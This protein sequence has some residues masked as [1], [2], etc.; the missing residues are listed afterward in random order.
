MPI[1]SK[2]DTGATTLEQILTSK[3]E[4]LVP[5]FQRNYSWTDEKVDRL[6]SDIMEN[7]VTYLESTDAQEAQYLMGPMVFVKKGNLFQVI[8]GQQRLATVTILFCVVRDLMI[9]LVPVQ[10]GV[11][12]PEGLAKVKELIETRRMGEHQFWTL[13]LNDSDKKLFK[14]IQEYEDNSWKTPADRIKDWKKDLR[15]PV[16]KNNYTESMRKIIKAYQI[17]YDK[18]QESLITNFESEKNAEL[19]IKKLETAAE[20]ES[21]DEIKNNPEEYGIDPDFFE[22]LN[23]INNLITEAEND[24]L[25]DDVKQK[26][27]ADLE[28][29][30]R[31]RTANPFA[32]VN[33]L[34]EDYKKNL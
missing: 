7:F 9:E 6:W 30:N 13:T 17:L 24:N 25:V 22:K 10:P 5:K 11:T 8:D 2:Y 31:T 12:A 3:T 34:L 16:K 27:E 21:V 20:N 33:E 18:I 19:I 15:D 29:R 1:A 26:L 28:S 14:Q 4:F 32:N 23:D